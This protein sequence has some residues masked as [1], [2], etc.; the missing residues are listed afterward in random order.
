[1]A[2]AVLSVDVERLHGELGSLPLEETTSNQD[3]SNYRL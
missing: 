2:T 1:M 3:H